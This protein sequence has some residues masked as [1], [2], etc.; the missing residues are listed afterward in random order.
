MVNDVRFL[1][2]SQHYSCHMRTW[3]FDIERFVQWMA[4][5]MDNLHFTSVFFNSISVISGRCMDDNE[6]KCAIELR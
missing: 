5:W 1:H 3:E 6:R 4:G 2:S